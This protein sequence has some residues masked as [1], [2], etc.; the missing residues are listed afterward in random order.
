MEKE[1]NVSKEQ[2]LLKRFLK[3]SF[4]PIILY[5]KKT[6]WFCWSLFGVAKSTL[7]IETITGLKII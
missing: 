7:R 5:K 2:T 1:H 6:D 4:N 3:F